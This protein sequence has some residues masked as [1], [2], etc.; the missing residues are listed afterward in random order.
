MKIINPSYVFAIFL[1]P[2]I[3]FLYSSILINQFEDDQNKRL[4][5]SVPSAA[6]Q[7]QSYIEIRRNI[8]TLFAETNIDLLEPLTN[9]NAT[10][11]EILTVEKATKQSMIA[12]VTDFYAF[13]VR[14]ADGNF[15]PDEFDERF[16]EFC[17]VDMG[18][19]LDKNIESINLGHIDKKNYL[20]YRPFIHPQ[21][22]HYHLDMVTPWKDTKGKVH[23]FSMLFET[24]GITDVL[25]MFEETGHQLLLLKQGSN[26]LIEI[27]SEGDRSI[28]GEHI[29]LTEDTVDKLLYKRK[30]K[31]SQWDIAYIKNPQ[32]LND[33]KKAIWTNVLYI[34]IMNLILFGLYLLFKKATNKI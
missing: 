33:Y 25:K 27:T 15:I 23:I 13:L 31:N 34:S 22:G 19:Y 10:E 12:T 11:E 7:I 16:G 24:K 29:N 17:R 28:L 1:I 2:S 8:M 18:K 20:S 6:R 5:L 21:P 3:S 14:S 4:A 9:K 32:V 30:I 26:T